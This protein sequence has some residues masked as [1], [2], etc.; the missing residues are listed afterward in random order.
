M[1]KLSAPVFPR[2]TFRQEDYVFLRALYQ[3][4]PCGLCG[5]TMWCVHREPEV[6]VAAHEARYNPKKEK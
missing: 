2:G 4:R 6:D 5:L 3:L 1:A